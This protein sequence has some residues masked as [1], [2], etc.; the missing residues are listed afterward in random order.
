MLTAPDGLGSGYDEV[1]RL[2]GAVRLF[3]R[4]GR[5]RQDRR[6]PAGLL[7]PDGAVDDRLDAGLARNSAEGLGGAVVR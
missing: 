1:P 2:H 6:A 4:K 3:H 7:R 5:G